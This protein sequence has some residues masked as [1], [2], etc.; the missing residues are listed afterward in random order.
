MRRMVFLWWAILVLGGGPLLVACGHKG[1]LYLP[2]HQAQKTQP[3]TSPPSTQA[4][5]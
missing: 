5:N 3:Q 2:D 4:P 1:P